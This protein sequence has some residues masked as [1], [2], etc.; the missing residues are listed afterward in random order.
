MVELTYLTVDRVAQLF[1][2]H[3]TLQGNASNILPLLVELVTQIL[4]E[5]TSILL[6]DRLKHKGRLKKYKPLI[7][8]EL[9]LTLKPSSV[10]LAR[11]LN[12]I[13]H[14]LNICHEIGQVVTLHRQRLI[15]FNKA[16]LH[17]LPIVSTSLSLD[18]TIMIRNTYLPNPLLGSEI[19]TF[20]A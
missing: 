1:N 9:N 19:R 17:A 7:L 5:L 14:L 12:V 15:L 10:I 6:R 18:V 16:A 13:V 3:F 20:V 2:L 4:A 11:A 8:E